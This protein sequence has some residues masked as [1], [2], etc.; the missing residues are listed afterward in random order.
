MKKSI[1][2]LFILFVL[3]HRMSGQDVEQILTN[4]PKL[5]Y[6]GSISGNMGYNAY[7]GNSPYTQPFTWA[8]GGTIGAK[9]FNIDLPFTFSLVR[10]QRQFQY[11]Q[12]NFNQFGISPHYRWVKVYAGHSNMTFSPYTLGGHTF[13]GAGIELTPK[14]FRL[15]AMYGRLLK[16]IEEDTTSVFS[17]IPTYCRMGYGV[18]VGVGSATNFF[19]LIYFK[20]KDDVTSITD[21]VRYTQIKPGENAVFGVTGRFLIK[22]VVFFNF[23]GAISAYTRDIR[24]KPIAFDGYEAVQRAVSKVIPVRLSTQVSSAVKA[25][26]GYNGKAFSAQANYERIDPEYASMGCFFFNN[27]VENYTIAPTFQL[28][29]NKLRLTGSYG[30]QRNNILKHK[31]L[32]TDRAIGSATMSYQ[33]NEKFGIDVNFTNYSLHQQSGKV[34][35]SDTIRIAN[36]NRNISITPRYTL[37]NE[38]KAQNFLAIFNQQGLIDQNPYTQQYSDVTTQFWGLNYSCSWLKSGQS[39]SLAL[40]Y[41]TTDTYQADI[42]SIG[43]S[44]GYSLSLKENRYIFSVNESF[45]KNSLNGENNGF[46]NNLNAQFTYQINTQQQ[47]GL[48]CNHL[49]YNTIQ[50]PNFSEVRLALTY[51]INLVKQKVEK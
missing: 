43:V 35:I 22:K 11:P 16:P 24:L 13:L 36:V 37:S 21:P 32:Q 30:V 44:A 5:E 2:I 50:Q 17:S 48:N 33:P 51:G 14:K 6:Y 8:I 19:D 15:A 3:H 29:K 4:K 45:S 25:N 9:I 38:H 27:D 41:I 7:F 49:I 23:D 40:N 12:F 39:L 34:L 31:D 10:Q 1:Y 26:I 42:K 47:I 46:N 18:K 28:F 20:A